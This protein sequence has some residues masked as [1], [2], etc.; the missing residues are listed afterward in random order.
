MK[1]INQL[2]KLLYNFINTMEFILVH[3]SLKNPGFHLSVFAALYIRE[4]F[5]IPLYLCNCYLPCAIFTSTLFLNLFKLKFMHLCSRS[6]L[7]CF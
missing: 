6:T 2:I 5:D 1:L 4:E 7:Q 3:S